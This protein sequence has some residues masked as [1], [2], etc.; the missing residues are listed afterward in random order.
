MTTA[1]QTQLPSVTISRE[2]IQELDSLIREEFNEV[3]LTVT[4][5]HEGIEQSYSSL[6]ELVSDQSLP[7]IVRTYQ[8]LIQSKG[9][10]A[11]IN[12]N[13]P[14][15]DQHDLYVEG[16]REWVEHA[17][18]VLLEFYRL[19]KNPIRSILRGQTRMAPLSLISSI[20]AGHFYITISPL[21]IYYPASETLLRIYTVYIFSAVAFFCSSFR[22]RL[23]PYV[24][25]DLRKES[26]ADRYVTSA[27]QI[28]GIVLLTLI[29]LPIF[30]LFF[31]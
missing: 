13:S 18:N 30:G 7:E 25:W 4:T 3:S 12:A 31:N 11:K 23:F 27:F 20:A 26:D 21:G 1:T 17:E 28:I 19:D 6:S 9:G 14:Q 5:L 24:Y 29:L 10:K 2:R 8:L 15:N 16:Y 22:H